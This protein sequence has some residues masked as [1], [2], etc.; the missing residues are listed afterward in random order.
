LIGYELYLAREQTFRQKFR[1]AKLLPEKLFNETRNQVF[2]KTWFLKSLIYS[3][4]EYNT[5]RFFFGIRGEN[6]SSKN[7]KPRMLLK[8]F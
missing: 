7:G 2:S 4:V 3:R 5:M 8:G 6:F 1:S